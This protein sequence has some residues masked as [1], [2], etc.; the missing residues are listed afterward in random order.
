MQSMMKLSLH[1]KIKNVVGIVI[2]IVGSMLNLLT[3]IFRMD[4]LYIK[5]LV[6]FA[7]IELT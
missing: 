2:L 6:R 3:S 7:I 1:Q 5:V 4:T